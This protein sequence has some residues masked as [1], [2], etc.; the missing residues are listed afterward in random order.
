[1]NVSCLFK[2]A[3]FFLKCFELLHKHALL[4]V[5]RFC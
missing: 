1:M 5:R 4:E 3:G 2:R